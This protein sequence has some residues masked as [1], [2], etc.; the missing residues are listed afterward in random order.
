M[1]NAVA[2]FITKEFGDRIVSLIDNETKVIVRITIGLEP[3]AYPRINR[4]SVLFVSISFIVL[5]IISLGM[6]L[7]GCVF[8]FTIS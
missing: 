1:E 2:I 5:M 7:G 6:I 8:S 4:T 3:N